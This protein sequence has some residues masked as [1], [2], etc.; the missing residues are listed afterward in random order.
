[1]KKIT[2]KISLFLSLFTSS[3]TLVCCAL[4]AVFVLLGAGSVFASLT[5]FFPQLIWIAEQKTYLFIL[6]GFFLTVTA[7][8]EYRNHKTVC[9][10]NQREACEPVRDWSKVILRMSILLYF[11]GLFFAFVLPLFL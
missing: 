2:S 1:M 8:L 7:Y 10:P 6:A 5:S 4:P 3:T 9:I 11:I